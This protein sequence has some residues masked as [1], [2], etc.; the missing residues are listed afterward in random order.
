LLGLHRQPETNTPQADRS[1]SE[2]F[3]EF[4]TRYL[5][6][7]YKY[8]TYK[9]AD[10]QLAE[11]LT[12]LVFEKALT[13]FKSHDSEKASFST[14]IFT[15]ARNTVIDH[16]RANS[17]VQTVEINSDDFSADGGDSPEESAIK[18]EEFRTLQG[19]VS[20]LSQTEQEIISLKFGAGMNNR[21]IA[22]MTGLSDSNI[23]TIIW[24][25]VGKL[26]DNFRGLENG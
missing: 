7:V 17:K 8:M 24:R 12:S 5:P 1:V 14:W 18:S 13:K 16:Y 6:K 21:Q 15:I 11:D 9:V 23:G 2:R 22:G 26:R 20:K 4:Y 10:I 3:S 25:A 19:F